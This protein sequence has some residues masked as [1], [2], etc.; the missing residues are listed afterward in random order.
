MRLMH[1][2]SSNQ[3]E[4]KKSEE[5]MQ[6]PE[7][8]RDIESEDKIEGK[9]KN[10]GRLETE[11]EGSLVA[12][13]R[14]GGLFPPWTAVKSKN[15]FTPNLALVCSPSDD[16]SHWRLELGTPDTEVLNH[17]LLVLLVFW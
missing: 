8:S 17:H 10:P 1:I 3:V 6:A 2:K 13:S 11:A 7:G 5:Q 16:C 15:S 9:P 4:V 12:Q 14:L